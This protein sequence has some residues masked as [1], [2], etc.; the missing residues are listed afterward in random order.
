[1][2][3]FLTDDSYRSEQGCDYAL[4]FYGKV[5]TWRWCGRLNRRGDR[6]L[7]NHQDFASDTYLAI[8]GDNKIVGGYS[9]ILDSGYENTVMTLIVEDADEHR[10]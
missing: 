3:F 1:M 10:R 5:Q 4:D 9:F 7:H 6:I 8:D 2:I